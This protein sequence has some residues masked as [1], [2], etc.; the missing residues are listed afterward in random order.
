MDD[1]VANISILLKNLDSFQ[2]FCTESDSTL[3]GQL[4]VRKNSNG[5][6]S[7]SRDPAYAYLILPLTKEFSYMRTCFISGRLSQGGESSVWY[8]QR[9]PCRSTYITNSRSW[10]KKVSPIAKNGLDNSTTTRCQALILAASSASE[11][12][13]T[14]I[15]YVQ[16]QAWCKLL[17]GRCK[18]FWIR[19]IFIAVRDGQYV[20]HKLHFNLALKRSWYLTMPTI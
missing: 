18:E 3:S 12:V 17:S 16:N 15:Q 9:I 13:Y 20:V 11:A 4:L 1:R 6:D 7:S 8:L 2:T 14:E 19:N 10:L 5:R